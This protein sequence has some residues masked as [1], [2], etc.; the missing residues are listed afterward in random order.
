M[1]ACSRIFRMIVAATSGARRIGRLAP[2]FHLLFL[3]AVLTVTL[4]TSGG[5]NAQAAKKGTD[6]T[7]ATV[8]RALLQLAPEDRAAVIEQFSDKQAKNLL[9]RTLST[10]PTGG[11][12]TGIASY[13][14]EAVRLKAAALREN[15]RAV[16]ARGL[17][18]I[19]E[20]RRA[21][22]ANLGVG[23]GGLLVV[24]AYLSALA[25]AGGLTE[26]VFRRLSKPLAV[27]NENGSCERTAK[28]LARA[29]V[30][31][32]LDLAAIAAFAVGYA[33]A[34]MLI[35]GGS[36]PTRDFT[37]VVLLVATVARVAMALFRFVAVPGHAR[38]RIVR[39][40]DE[41]TL[42]LVH[43]LRGQIVLG[44]CLF[45]I[46][47]LGR[48]WGVAHDVWRLLV[49]VNSTVFAVSAVLILWRYRGHLLEVGASTVP[50][51][52]SSAW[53]RS[54]AGAMWSL[55]AFGY[56]CI[57][58]MIGMYSLLLD[59]AFDPLRAA[60]GFFVL[61]VGYPYLAALLTEL[62]TPI[63]VDRETDAR[64]TAG[65]APQDEAP[66]EPAEAT[67][68]RQEARPL[69]ALPAMAR[70]RRVLARLVSIVAF[71]ICLAAFSVVAGL[72]F[73]SSARENPVV[74]VVVRVLLDSGLV[75]LFGFFAWAF[76]AEKIDQRLAADQAASATAG[77]AALQAGTRL[78]T[79]LPIARKFIQFFIGLMVGMVVLA[80][81]GVQIGPL[82]AGAGV[83]G[84][85]VG[86]GSQTL[87]KDLISGLF[88]LMDDA[89]R[90]GEFIACDNASGSVERFNARSL[91]LRGLLG[92]V[93][94]IP[95]S[96]LG[97]VTNYSRDWAL[98]KMSFR[99]PFDTDIG[100]VRRLFK[101]IGKEL[102]ED[103]EL[104]PDFIEPFKTQGVSKMDD[105]GFIIR[106]KFMTKPNKQFT[107]QRRIYEEV[108]KAFRENG[109]VFAPNRLVV[110]IPGNGRRSEERDAA[111]D[112]VQAAPA[113]EDPVAVPQG[114]TP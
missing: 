98:V 19:P 25:A 42:R 37:V 70:D 3:A 93:Y 85:A 78:Q 7:D 36:Q 64:A 107:I 104:A 110:D 29:A 47:I 76:I 6:K 63:S 44:A 77:D 97:A 54:A 112:E 10:A 17:D 33:A 71:I 21:M 35:W 73:F 41:T 8:T 39:L 72:G 40:D 88:F 56:V 20:F 60:A 80:S 82:L 50:S 11:A 79:L 45:L 113:A 66:P 96:S 109:I 100:L 12:A 28:R 2:G 83:V 92:E 9:L 95:Y 84:I 52:D 51:L 15:L 101:K 81:M 106:G 18:L 53:T 69:R 16:L 57:A 86:F 111:K 22:Q 99:V 65:G 68:P 108:Q 102:L 74:G 91:V 94:T 49:L 14:V 62:V 38:W 4:V 75:V 27:R 43:G 31:G 48:M 114:G 32:A 23:E 105:S 55:L 59:Q 61:L 13:S 30:Q 103:P 87:V 5:A 26:W 34:F 24:L 67:E 58:F 46:S 90:L 89:F 1:E